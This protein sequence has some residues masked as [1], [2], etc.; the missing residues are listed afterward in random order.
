RVNKTDGSHDLHVFHRFNYERKFFE[1]DQP[2]LATPLPQ[3]GTIQRFGPAYVTGNLKDQA[4]YNMMHNRGGV[5]YDNAT[6]GTIGVFAEDFRFNYYFGRILINDGEIN[7]GSSSD[8]FQTVG[9]FYN[10]SRG[11]LAL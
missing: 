10:F 11:A 5:S 7:T 4:R 8:A 3:G 6:L 1:F 9:A 2:T